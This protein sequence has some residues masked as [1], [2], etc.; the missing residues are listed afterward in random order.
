[1][2]NQTSRAS[3]YQAMKP[4]PAPIT[5]YEA[6]PNSEKRSTMVFYG[7]LDSRQISDSIKDAAL[8][9]IRRIAEGSD[10]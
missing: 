5:S 2:V 7:N 1:M 3:Q 8:I 10:K 9:E 6:G 4:N